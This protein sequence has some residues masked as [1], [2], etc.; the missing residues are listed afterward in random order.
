MVRVVT[1]RGEHNP[2]LLVVLAQK[3]DD[4]AKRQCSK[5]PNDVLP[6]LRSEDC[7]FSPSRDYRQCY[8][9]FSSYLL[10]P[11][12]TVVTEQGEHNPL[13]FFIHLER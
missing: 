1:E 7:M 4:D 3:I 6:R 13:L 8:V 11:R 5:G 10:G 12:S 2:H 9:H